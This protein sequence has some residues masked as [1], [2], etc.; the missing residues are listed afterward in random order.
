MISAA[1]LAYRSRDNLARNMGTASDTPRSLLSSSRRRSPLS[2]DASYLLPILLFL[3]LTWVG[4][5]WPSL[6]PISYVAK[7]I[8]CT[9]ALIAC[10][11]AYTRIRWNG[12]WLGVALGAVGIVQWIG[13]QLLLQRAFAGM[14]PGYRFFQPP[15][16]AEQFNPFDAIQ[17]S[18]AAMAFVAVRI[19]S[20]TLLVPVI[21]ELFWRDYLWRRLISPNNF[22]LARVGEWDRLAFFAI[23]IAFATVHGHWWLTAILW[24]FLIGG[25]LRYTQSLGACIAMHAT[26]N[27]LLAG[28]VLYTGDYS[29]W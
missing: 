1:A 28:Y 22:K 13:V 4:G 20:A 29:F 11:P 15:P 5:Q 2:D 12:W 19:A 23:P 3:A 10:W 9:V 18:V 26:S 8:L 21:E 7:A 6:Y 17:P 24:A 25:L 16:I 14:S 27:L